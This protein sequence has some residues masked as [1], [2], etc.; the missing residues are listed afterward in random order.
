MRRDYPRGSE[1]AIRS[2]RHAISSDGSRVFFETVP[3][4]NCSEPKNLYLRE[5]TT[6]TV[7]IGEYKFA[8]ATAEGRR[9]YSKSPSVERTELLLYE[10][11]SGSIRPLFAVEGAHLHVS[12]ELIAVYWFSA[13]RR[14]RNGQAPALNPAE[15]PACGK[16]LSLRCRYDQEA[17]FH[18]SA[19]AQANTVEALQISPNGRYFY[20]NRVRLV[21]SPV[22]RLYP[23]AAPKRD[24]KMTAPAALYEPD[25][26]L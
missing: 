9:C 4:A 8:A 11:G 19:K 15:A 18:R 23:M 6:K 14:P 22:V 21:V 7:D 13:E 26:S 24:A 25:L 5:G 16:S 10:T 12:E 20:F 17:R 1:E 3:G 2:V